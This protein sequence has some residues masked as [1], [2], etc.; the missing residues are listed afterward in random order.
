MYASAVLGFRTFRLDGDA[1]LSTGD[2][3][4][5]WR[6]GVQVAYCH[7]DDD[8][9]AAHDA[10]DTACRC[11][12]YAFHD[13]TDAMNLAQ[14]PPVVGAVAARGQVLLHAD[15]F[16]AQEMALLALAWAGTQPPAAHQRQQ[17]QRCADRYRV[18]VLDAVSLP[19]Y[20]T[21]SALPAPEDAVAPLRAALRDERRRA[22]TADL[23]ALRV[24]SFAF[25]S[26]AAIF[27]AALLTV[28]VT[29]GITMIAAS[30]LVLAAGAGALTVITRQLTVAARRKLRAVQSSA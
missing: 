20:G 25:A 7:A 22:L 12:L 6:P 18:P 9:P 1:L 10:P 5:R 29:S 11:G 19:A 24:A 15:G 27:L 4:S 21:L 14:V 13:L 23:R 17:L 28:V 8:R 30:Q 2:G 16:R 26:F 3:R